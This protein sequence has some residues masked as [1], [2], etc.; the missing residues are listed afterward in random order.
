MMLLKK[1]KYNK[2]ILTR[3]K[4]WVGRKDDDVVIQGIQRSSSREF[5]LKFFVGTRL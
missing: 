2:Y 4:V 1:D 3:I 5:C